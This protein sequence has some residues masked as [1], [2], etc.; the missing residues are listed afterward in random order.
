MGLCESKASLVDVEFQSNSEE[1]LRRWEPF[2][3]NEMKDHFHAL[4][5][6]LS[7][8]QV[9]GWKVRRTPLCKFRMWSIDHKDS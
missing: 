2:C 6:S 7:G 5:R 3:L 1:L 8:Y 4:L 9:L